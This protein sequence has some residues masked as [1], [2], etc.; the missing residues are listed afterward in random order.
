LYSQYG[1]KELAVLPSDIEIYI[2]LLRK[3]FFKAKHNMDVYDTYLAKTNKQVNG[4]GVY[5]YYKGLYYLGVNKIDSA[6]Y[7]FERELYTSRDY[8]SKQAAAKG[9]FMIYKKKM[10]ADSIA[11]YSELWNNAVDSSYAHM[12][13]RHLQQMHAIFDYSRSQKLA[14][15][16]ASE[17][18]LADENERYSDILYRYNQLIDDMH[19]LKSDSTSY[20]HNKE[21]EIDQLR[22]QLSL[23]QG[24][25][26]KSE[27]LNIEQNLLSHQI[28]RK[29]HGLARH[30]IVPSDAEWKALES[31]VSE[32][33]SDFYCHINAPEYKLSAAELKTCILIRLSFIPS[34]ISVLLDI[35]KQRMTNIRASIN[36]KL[37]QLDGTK[38]VD[39]RIREL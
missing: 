24:V 37:F 10:D 30:S 32:L 12:A 16:K 8:N 36:K 35:T 33:L 28:V 7:Y 17:N 31:L 13:T 34:E 29:M 6:R 19:N 3:D 18:R 38:Q 11:K 25:Q 5:D 23:Y 39:I 27:A 14:A 26:D 9:L 20:Q 1:Y 4:Y 15:D 22:Q 21:L 2:Y